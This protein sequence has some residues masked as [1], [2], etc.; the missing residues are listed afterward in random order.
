MATEDSHLEQL[1]VKTTFLHGDLEKEI[2]MEQP[3]G[4]KVKGKE[5]LVCRLKK[6]LY[7]LKQAPRQWYIRFDNLMTKHGYSQCHLDPCSYFSRFD[8]GSY[9]ILCLYV[10]D[11]LLARSNIDHIKRLK[12]WLAHPFAMKDLGAAKQIHGMKICRD[13]RNT[14]LILSQ[15][16]YVEKVLQ[17]FYMTN[18]KPVNTPSPSHL[19]FT[20]DMC[21]KT[22]EE[23]RMSKVPHALVIGS[24]MND[25]VCTRLVVQVV[26]RYMDHLRIEHWNAVKWILK[27]LRSTSSSYLRFRGF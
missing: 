20:K 18:T 21:P 10:D 11:I 6:S 25:R 13:R 3:Q 12:Q 4:F 15:V 1:D 14:K 16:D 7:G 23:D 17:R 5:N 9:I 19:K 8:N 26:T 24:L 27:Y 22:Q 2:Y